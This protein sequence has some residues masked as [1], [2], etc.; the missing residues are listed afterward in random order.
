MLFALFGAV[1]LLAVVLAG[2]VGWGLYRWV[3]SLAESQSTAGQADK[4]EPGTSSTDS[5]TSLETTKPLRWASQSIRFVRV[6]GGQVPDVVGRAYWESGHELALFNG[7]TGKVLWH[8]PTD[9]GGEEYADGQDGLLVATSSN[10]LVRYAAQTGDQR[11]KIQIAEYISDVTFGPGCA[12][13]MLTK[14]KEPVGVSLGTGAAQACPGAP[15]G[16]YRRIRL[17]PKDARFNHGAWTIESS[18]QRD[19]KP[20]NPDPPRIVVRVSQGGRELF[21]QASLPI[22]PIDGQFA[23]VADSDAGVFVFGRSPAGKTAWGLIELPSGRVVY[24]RVGTVTVKFNEGTPAIAGARSM[25]FVQHDWM[26]EA[27]EPRTGR[28]VWTAS[29]Q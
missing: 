8:R 10:A 12:S 20:I 15:P 17:E 5:K 3:A 25:V 23:L 6:S 7:A 9:G 19:P 11:W 2:V 14:T 13:L 18:I 29:E 27:Y 21:R 1:V 24:S 4:R 22:E 16:E 28:L 26:L